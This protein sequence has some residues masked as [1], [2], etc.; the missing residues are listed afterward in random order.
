MKP[1]PGERV[2]TPPGFLATAY[3]QF[4]EG[5]WTGLTARLSRA[6]PA[7]HHGVPL[8]E[9]VNASNPRGGNFP[10]PSH[11]A[12]EVLKPPRRGVAAG[13]LPEAAYR[14]PLT[15]TMCLTEPHCGVVDLGLLKT[16]V[17]EPT[18]TG[19]YA[20]TAP[21]SSSPASTT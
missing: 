9:T 1:A 19:S 4:V 20:I 17:S 8:N 12:V 13:G 18:W 15:G 14:G 16:K 10:L 2:T 7:A 11:G 3:A 21:R 6:G 5:G